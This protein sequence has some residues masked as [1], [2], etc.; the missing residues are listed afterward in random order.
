MI[1]DDDPLNDFYTLSPDKQAEVIDFIVRLK[2]KQSDSQK[3]WKE[4]AGL[5]EFPVMPMDAQSWVSHHRQEADRMY[6]RAK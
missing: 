4:L 6:D 2:K 3:Q 1:Q 5:L